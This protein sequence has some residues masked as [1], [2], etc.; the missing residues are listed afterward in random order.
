M[1]PVKCK[2]ISSIGAI[3]DIPP[4]VAPPFIPKTGP[5]DGSLNANI[6]F[7]PNFDK[8]SAIDIDTVVFPSPKGVGLMAVT[9][10]NFP[11]SFFSNLLY[12][13]LDTFALYFPYCS[14]S[15]SFIPMFSAISAIFFN[16]IF[17]AISISVI[18]FH[19]FF[20]IL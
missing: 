16:L 19:P 14:I 17:L 4:P 9:N 5:N 15:F 7:F 10:T 2:F 3:C 6:D 18:I 11:F 20:F 12:V 8:A 1:S 13:L